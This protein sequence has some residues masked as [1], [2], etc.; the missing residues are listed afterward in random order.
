MTSLLIGATTLGIQE[1]SHAGVPL[2][3]VGHRLTASQ[4]Y[5][6]PH[7]PESDTRA[8]PKSNP[9]VPRKPQVDFLTR[10]TSARNVEAE[11]V[12][13]VLNETPFGPWLGAGLGATFKV[14]YTSPNDFKPVAFERDQADVLPV[15][16]AL[17]S[18]IPLAIAFC[19]LLLYLCWRTF[20][21]LGELQRPDLTLAIFALSVLP[22]V[23]LG[24][25]A[26]NPIIW[27]TFG[28]AS[29]NC[30]FYRKR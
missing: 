3:D 6:A 14:S 29:R 26:T 25:N 10:F 9:P 18:G 2:L 22:D 5:H 28:Y 24:F 11:S 27:G 7:S 19:I 8:S 20:A 23:V 21:A 17:T 16:L 1:L 4:A 12:W 13:R 30:V 15:H